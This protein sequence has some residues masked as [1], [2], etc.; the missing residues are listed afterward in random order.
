SPWEFDL[1]V[2][3][4]DIEEKFIGLREILYKPKNKLTSFNYGIIDLNDQN[5]QIELGTSTGMEKL[6]DSLN[7]IKI[8]YK[9]LDEDV[10][11]LKRNLPEGWYN[12]NIVTPIFDDCMAKLME[13]VLSGNYLQD[14]FYALILYFNQ[15]LWPLFL[16]SGEITSKIQKATIKNPKKR[17]KYNGIMS[18]TNSIEFI[19]IETATTTDAS[20]QIKDLSKLYEAISI[21]FRQ[22]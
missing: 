3:N 1:I 2:E 5:I 16:N 13:F 7:S 6:A 9:N 22:L 14:F 17:K 11:Y 8:N 10:L 15:L 20:K 12:S 19:Y 4:I 18:L 21:M